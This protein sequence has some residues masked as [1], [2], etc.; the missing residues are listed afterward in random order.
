ME[1]TILFQDLFNV[2][3]GHPIAPEEGF[4]IFINHFALG[5][6]IRPTHWASSNCFEFPEI[7][8]SSHFS[9]YI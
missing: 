7:R 8:S 6:T 4:V 9:L 1:G 3:E 5:L 2:I